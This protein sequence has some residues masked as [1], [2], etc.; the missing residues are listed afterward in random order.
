MQ[1]PK[2][3]IENKMTFKGISMLSMRWGGYP[4]DNSIVVYQGPIVT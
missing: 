1:F 2:P 3:L 4:E